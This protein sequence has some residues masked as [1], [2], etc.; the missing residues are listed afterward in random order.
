MGRL[1]RNGA[2][3]CDRRPTRRSSQRAIHAG[4]FR[5]SAAISSNVRPSPSS[6]AFL[7][8][9]VCQRCT[10]HVDVLRIQLDAEADALG[11]FRGRQRGAAAEE[12][13]VNQFAA[14]EVVQDRA[15]HQLDRLL[16]GVIELLLV[17][18]RP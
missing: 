3:P 17:A 9:S 16:R 4:S 7:P 10:I 11:Q 6:V 8:V 18:S 1:A 13:I 15:P 5:R 12:R 14:L 2:N